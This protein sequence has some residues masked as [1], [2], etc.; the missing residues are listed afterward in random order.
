MITLISR[1]YQKKEDSMKLIRTEKG[2]NDFM[3]TGLTLGKIM[4]F[5]NALE[6]VQPGPVGDEALAELKYW[7]LDK[8]ECFGEDR[9][10]NNKTTKASI[11]VYK[12]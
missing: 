3:I 4:A 12:V 7:E 6:M 8:I 11:H 10:E 5:Q 2:K 9:T 1:K